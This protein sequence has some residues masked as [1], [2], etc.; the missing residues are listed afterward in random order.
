MIKGK[1]S[2]RKKESNRDRNRPNDEGKV[3]NQDGRQ[4]EAGRSLRPNFSLFADSGLTQEEEKI[5]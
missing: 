5:I 3:R 1:N 4:G 2:R